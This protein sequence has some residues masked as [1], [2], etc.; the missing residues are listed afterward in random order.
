[1]SWL[2]LHAL[3]RALQLDI[4]SLRGHESRLL[5]NAA[6]STE[7]VIPQARGREGRWVVA[8]RHVQA[9]S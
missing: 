2:P 3:H 5:A 7:A 1:M 6:R 9:P 4:S 8:H